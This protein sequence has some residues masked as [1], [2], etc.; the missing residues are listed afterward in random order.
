M[1]TQLVEFPPQKSSLCSDEG[2]GN[3]K[4]YWPFFTLMEKTLNNS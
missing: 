3:I 4:T 2:K 1:K